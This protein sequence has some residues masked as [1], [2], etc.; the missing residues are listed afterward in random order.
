MLR[1]SVAFALM[2]ARKLA[3]GLKQGLTEDERYRVADDV[4]EQL[5]RRGDP[6]RLSEELPERASVE[7]PPS[8][9]RDKWTP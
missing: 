3:R 6:W 9:M 5:K 4:V 8:P 7:P 2:H 1:F